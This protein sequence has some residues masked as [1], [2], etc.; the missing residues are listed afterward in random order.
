MPRNFTS[1]ASAAILA[2]SVAGLLGGCA[3]TGSIDWDNIGS[4]V[5]EGVDSARGA[6]ADAQAQAD[7]LGAAGQ[8]AKD[9]IGQ[10][11]TAIDQARSVAE[12]GQDASAEAIDQA[13]SAVAEATSAVDSAAKNAPSQLAGPLRS[14][15][16]QLSGLA[17]QLDELG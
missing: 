3:D 16:D 14:L 17:D 15:S 11:S 8:Q 9:A 1:A 2:T 10:A 6:V 7:A 12:Q 13:K 5:Q 4:Q